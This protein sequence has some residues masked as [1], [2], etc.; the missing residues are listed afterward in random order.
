MRGNTNRNGKKKAIR[1]RREVVRQHAHT[2][3]TCDDDF[4]HFDRGLVVREKRLRRIV[5]R[6]W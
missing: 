2:G 6:R 4:D 1:D 3:S 5:G